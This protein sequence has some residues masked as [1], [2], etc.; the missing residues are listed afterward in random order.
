M[1]LTWQERLDQQPKLRNINNWPT[2]DALSLPKN[3]RRQFL[4]NQKI[5]SKALMGA[6]LIQVEK[7]F[8]FTCGRL[9]HFLNRCLAGDSEEN[10][11]LTKALIPYYRVAL[12][13]RQQ[14]LPTLNDHKGSQYAFQHLLQTA[15]GL[16]IFLNK[17]LK[18]HVRRHKNGQNLSVG[19][20]HKAMIRYLRESNWQM[21]SYP[22]TCTSYAYE[23]T[24]RY[25]HEYINELNTPS[26][27]KRIILP[28][29]RALGIFE[30]IEIDEHTTDAETMCQLMLNDLWEPL[31]LSRVTLITAR[32]IA[33]N[34]IIARHTVLSQ[35]VNASDILIFLSQLV[36][37]WKAFTLETPGL[38]LPQ[39]PWMPSALGDEFLRPMIGIIRL[40]NALVHLSKD[41]EHFICNVLGAT[42]NLGLPK[43]PAARSIIESAF[44]DINLT[45]HRLRSTTG[46]YPTDPIKEPNRH[47]KTPPIVSLKTL[48]EM[49]D[50]HIA[51]MNTRRMGNIGCQTPIQLLKYQMAQHWVPLRP[52][53]VL[54]NDNPLEASTVVIVKHEKSKRREPWV[55]LLYV[56]YSAPG[57]IPLSFIGKKILI[58]YRIN[59]ICYV[60]A[61]T[62]EGEYLGEL[63]APKTWLRFEHGV[64]TRRYIMRLI[65][66]ERLQQSDPLGSYYDYL[67]H[68]RDTP[69]VAL[70]M[71]RVNREIIDTSEKSESTVVPDMLQDQQKHLSHTPH[72]SIPD[73]SSTMLSQRGRHY[74]N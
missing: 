37:P 66:E 38:D 54:G 2:I 29:T 49:I 64:T 32:D 59:A 8:G 40:D 62:L 31:R 18:K 25:Y 35:N 44:R 58:K 11:P 15:S 20:F 67:L 9:T 43:Q 36:S 52:D 55:N 30:E 57:V 21:S 24:R 51:A 3:K 73:W 41:V 72:K 48:E 69:S 1:Y 12:G 63:N 71:V 42:L 7:D 13:Q 10:P 6:P 34:A 26:V 14:T 65:K 45:T 17:L 28:K 39:T 50:V 5:L 16:K 23:A 33:S 61:Y 53:C 70:E 19:A 47:C 60:K 56:R 68:H 22:F 46:S 74:D 4:R 27:P